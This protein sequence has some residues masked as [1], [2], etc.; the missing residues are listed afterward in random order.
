[1]VENLVDRRALEHAMIEQL[2]RGNN[3]RPCGHPPVAKAAHL[4][5]P[6]FTLEKLL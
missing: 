4:S 3:E 6:S 2:R 1:V 5:S